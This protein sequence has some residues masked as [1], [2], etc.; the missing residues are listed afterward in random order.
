MRILITAGPTREYL[1][2]VRFISNASSG[3]M[4]Y[5]IASAAVAAGH[6]V[7][8]LTGPVALT[9]PDG[10]RCV[11]FESV[12]E[13]QSSLNE[14]FDACDVL[15]MTAAVGDFRPQT[16][17]ATKLARSDG[18]ISLTLTPTDDVVAAVAARK[19]ADQRV[20]AFAVEDAERPAAEEKARRELA[21]KH[22][23]YVVVNTPA[24]FG[25]EASDACI[26]AADGTVLPWADRDKTRLA[27]E[28]IQLL[29][30]T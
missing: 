13:L 5:A 9:E 19:R 7:T 10:C 25:A 29:E 14:H 26:L 16:P 2:P 21:A 8:L 30:N 4:G 17:A 23:D 24:A 6:D 15:I 3:R 12:A 20:V 18:A 27:S 11:R 28:I 22:A 1:D